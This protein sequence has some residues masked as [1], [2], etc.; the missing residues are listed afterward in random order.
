MEQ[1]KMNLLKGMIQTD[2][3]KKLVQLVEDATNLTSSDICTLLE[4]AHSLPRIIK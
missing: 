1:E 2:A 4:V 3:D